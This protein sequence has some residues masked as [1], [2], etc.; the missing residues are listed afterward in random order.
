M[1]STMVVCDCR[2]YSDSTG[3]EESVD[4]LF[5]LYRINVSPISKINERKKSL[6]H[7]I[8]LFNG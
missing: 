6:S 4:F 2:V 3:H 7:Q 8:N 5:N 1:C